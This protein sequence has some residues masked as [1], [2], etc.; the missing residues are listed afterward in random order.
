[1]RK[2]DEAVA[3]WSPQ[4]VEQCAERQRSILTDAW[5]ALRPGG[6]LIYSTCT[7]NRQENE[8]IADFIVNELGAVS[9]A[10]S[11]RRRRTLYGRIPQ[12]W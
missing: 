4:L 3:Q 6:L 11:C 12:G 10:A 1:M 9:H 5:N 8:E 2:D 7:Y